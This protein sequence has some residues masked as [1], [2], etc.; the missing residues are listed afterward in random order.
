[1]KHKNIFKIITLTA[2]AFFSTACVFD[3][4]E[5]VNPNAPS[6]EGV[7]NNASKGQLQNLVTGLE[8][9]HRL[10]MTGTSNLTAFYGSLGREVYA[11]YSSDP[12]FTDDWLGRA[13][14][15]EAYPD[16]FASIRHFNSPYKAIKQANVLIKSV[17]NTGVVTNQEASG[18]TGFA[19]TACH[20]NTQ[21]L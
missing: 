15:T 13:G 17:E 20:A 21:S 9:R 3:V 10:Y 11:Y 5:V 6:V 19:N 8:D 14:I 1:M 16:F 2:F 18:Y 12:R 4:D 7:L